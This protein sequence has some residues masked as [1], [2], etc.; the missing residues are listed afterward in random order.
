[1]RLQTFKKKTQLEPS[2]FKTKITILM[3]AEIAGNK[4]ESFAFCSNNIATCFSALV[5]TYEKKLIE[6][7][8]DILIA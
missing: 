4:L 6:K 2:P 3:V 1:M 5:Q 7:T 8:G